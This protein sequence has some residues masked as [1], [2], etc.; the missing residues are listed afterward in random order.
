MADFPDPS[1]TPEIT[2]VVPAYNE[3]NRLGSTLES[4][5]AYFEQRRTAVEILVVD[6]GSTDRTAEL[7]SA[8][9]Q[10]LPF[11]RL[12]T[13]PRNRGKGYAVKFGMANARGRLRL[14]DDA[15]GSTPISEI[16]RLESAIAAGADVAAGSRAKPSTDTAVEALWYRKLLGRTFNFFVNALI[17]PDIADTQC[18]FKMFTAMAGERLF[19][20]LTSERFSFDVE[21]LFLARKKGFKIAEV[22]VNWHNVPGSKVNLA[23]DSIS[24]LL[25]IFRFRWNYLAGKYS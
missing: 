21:L 11:V 7:V 14:F 9:G 16:E 15:D 25:D 3:E 17:V 22:P 18:G 4:I 24:M 12:L 6:D 13:Y 5:A 19:P 20:L 2:V 1:T 10:R 23:V 8:C